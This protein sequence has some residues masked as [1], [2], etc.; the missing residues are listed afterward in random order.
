M[1]MSLANR[2]KL[3]EKKREREKLT[4]VVRP[5]AQVKSA[6]GEHKVSILT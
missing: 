4:P 2:V 6:A 5:N 1:T 3:K